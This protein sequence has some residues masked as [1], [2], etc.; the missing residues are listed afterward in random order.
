MSKIIYPLLIFIFVVLIL[1]AGCS[2]ISNTPATSPP[3]ASS[4]SPTSYS[5]NVPGPAATPSQTTILSQADQAVYAKMT[6]M[7]SYTVP[8]EKDVGYSAESQNYTTARQN[9]VALR[10]YIDQ[11]LPELQQL[12]NN[13]SL[14]KPAAQEAVLGFMDLRSGEDDFAKGI[15]YMNAGDI[16]NANTM[17]TNATKLVLESTTHFHNAETLASPS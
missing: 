11:N 10:D 2:S 13:A 7:L 6:T 9:A 17:I 15:D 5:S 3:S 1:A 16:S 14:E 4:A 8:L 12:A